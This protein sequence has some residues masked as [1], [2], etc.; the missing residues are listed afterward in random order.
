LL[1]HKSLL[2]KSDS[3]IYFEDYYKTGDLIEW[4]NKENGIFRFKSRK[5]ELINVGGYKVNP[6]EIENTIMQIE[7]IQ[8]VIVYGKSNSVLGNILCAKVKLEDGFFL[9][10]LYIRQYLSD[11]LQEFKIPR[12]IKFV[13]S[14]SLTKT[15]KI[16]RL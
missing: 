2:G 5:N 12:I 8:Q 9:S 11:K 7:G 4:I 1:V 15:G 10:E 3:F 16:K 6:E 14:F 13:E